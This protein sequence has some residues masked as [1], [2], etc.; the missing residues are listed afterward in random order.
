MEGAGDA[1]DAVDPF[2]HIVPIEILSN[3]PADFYDKMV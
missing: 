1:V 2:E 3:L